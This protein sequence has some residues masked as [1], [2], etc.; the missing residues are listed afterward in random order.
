MKLRILEETNGQKLLSSKN[1]NS[2]YPVWFQ[3]DVADE[4]LKSNKNLTESCIE[5]YDTTIKKAS[6]G[7]Y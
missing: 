4:L 2:K 7:E 5:I 3:D 6:F 1:Y